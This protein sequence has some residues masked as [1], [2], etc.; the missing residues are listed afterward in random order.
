MVP[1]PK[2]VLY[3]STL[4]NQSSAYNMKTHIYKTEFIDKMA[5]QLRERERERERTFGCGL[6]V[7]IIS[8]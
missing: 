3:I 6:S 2:Y 8:N 1:Q 7:A 4:S 5:A